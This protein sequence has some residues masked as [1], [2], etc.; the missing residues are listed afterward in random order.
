MSQPSET[1]GELEEFSGNASPD[2]KK[3]FYSR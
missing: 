2:T 1:A 3:E